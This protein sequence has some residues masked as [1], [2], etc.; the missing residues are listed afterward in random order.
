MTYERSLDM[1][2][3][4]LYS[5]NTELAY[6][7][8]GLVAYYECDWTRQGFADL[9]KTMGRVLEEWARGSPAKSRVDREVSKRHLQREV[10]VEIHDWEVWR[11]WWRTCIEECFPTFTKSGELRITYK[12]RECFSKS[13][14]K[15]RMISQPISLP[16][17]SI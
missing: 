4:M 1:L 5:W 3:A 15:C 8:L 17:T 9:L 10:Y 7:E 16:W 14:V 2:K 6:Q 12:S 11:N 13:T